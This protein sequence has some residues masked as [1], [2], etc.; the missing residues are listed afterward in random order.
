M[1]QKVR[2]SYNQ[3]IEEGISE[4]VNALEEIKVEGFEFNDYEDLFELN[5]KKKKSNHEI[6]KVVVK[7]W[8]ESDLGLI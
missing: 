4:I 3:R 1:N 5:L 7:K 6:L 8:L 2:N